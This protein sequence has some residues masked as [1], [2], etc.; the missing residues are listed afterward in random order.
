MSKIPLEI[1]YGNIRVTIGVLLY[2]LLFSKK[3]TNKSTKPLRRTTFPYFQAGYS[4]HDRVWKSFKPWGVYV[5]LATFPVV[6]A[7]EGS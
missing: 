2:R 3:E 7:N 6:V 5:G 1:S 4:L